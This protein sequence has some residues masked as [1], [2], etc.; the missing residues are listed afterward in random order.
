MVGSPEIARCGRVLLID[1]PAWLNELSSRYRYLSNVADARNELHLRWLRRLGFNFEPAV[2]YGPQGKLFI[3]FGMEIGENVR[4][5]D[6]RWFGN[7]GRIC[8]R[9]RSRS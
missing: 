5:A 7:D 6:G 4:S 9:Q 3:P 2:A 1:A 8:R